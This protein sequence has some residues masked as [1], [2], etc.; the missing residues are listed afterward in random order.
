MGICSFISIDTYGTPEP[1]PQPKDKKLFSKV[2]KTES[3]LYYLDVKENSRGVFLLMSEVFPDGR[4]AQVHL[5]LDSVEK[6]RQHLADFVE[7]LLQNPG[8]ARD[9]RNR[10]EAGANTN[11]ATTSSAGKLKSALI[12]EP[13]RR[14]FLDLSVS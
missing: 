1:A 14:C 12:V 3:K 13:N 2:I 8:T 5:T 7:Y 10:N 6:F 4:R 11:A 9:G